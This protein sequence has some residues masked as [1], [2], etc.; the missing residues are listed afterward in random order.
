MKRIIPAILLATIW[1]SVSEFVRNQFWLNS[2]WTAHY[3]GMGLVFPQAPANG[4]VWGIWSL[5]FAGCIYVLS[6]RFSL[7]E[8]AALAWVIGFVL[9]WLV[10][11]NLGVLPMGLLPVAVPLSML[12]AFGA[13]W[14]IHRI[15]GPRQ[16]A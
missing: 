1:I 11:G 6:R 15:A 12:E 16:T 9:M 7:R 8:T 14:I 4:A 3:T 2:Y 13:A 5:C 10:I